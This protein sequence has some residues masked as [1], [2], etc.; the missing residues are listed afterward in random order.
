L[1]RNTIHNDGVYVKASK[2][3]NSSE[4]SGKTYEFKHN[5]YV[6]YPD[7]VRPSNLLLLQITP[8]HR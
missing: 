8:C 1:I 6:K 4:Y 3:Y 5:G 2:R 7:G